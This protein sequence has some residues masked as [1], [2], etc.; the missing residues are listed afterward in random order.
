MTYS[1]THLLTYSHSFAFKNGLQAREIAA[2]SNI[3]A[4]RKFG[5]DRN[6]DLRVGV[7]R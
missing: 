1:P 3:V 5:N 7:G 6:S 4:V 2:N